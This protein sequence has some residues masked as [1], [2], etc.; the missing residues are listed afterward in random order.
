MWLSFCIFYFMFWSICYVICPVSLGNTKCNDIPVIVLIHRATPTYFSI[1]YDYHFLFPLSFR[2]SLIKLPVAIFIFILFRWNNKLIWKGTALYWVFK[3]VKMMHTSI[4][5]S[6]PTL[7]NNIVC[8]IEVFVFFIIF[9]SR[10]LKTL[11]S[12]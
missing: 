10:Y 9:I 7:I 2:I 11:T 4:S 12:L 5:I 3:A 8:H 6:S 1:I